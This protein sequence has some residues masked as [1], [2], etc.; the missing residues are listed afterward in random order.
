VAENMVNH[1]A[2]PQ[3]R[4]GL[5][6]ILECGACTKHRPCRCSRGSSRLASK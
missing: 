1:A 5:R 4:E 2:G 6:Q 3:G